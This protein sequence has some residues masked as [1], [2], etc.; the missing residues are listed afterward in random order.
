MRL[1]WRKGAG[2]GEA[3]LAIEDAR[4]TWL[5]QIGTLVLLGLMWA[6]F[7]HLAVF[8]R[9]RSLEGVD[10]RSSN[11]ALAAQQYAERL[12]GIADA[13]TQLVAAEYVSG[14]RGRTLGQVLK[15]RDENNDALQEVFM[16]DP[17]GR[18]LLSSR[19]TSALVQPLALPREAPADRV[20]VLPPLGPESP[21]NALHLVPMVR[22]IMVDGVLRGWAG[23][24]IGSRRFADPLGATQLEFDTL[25][26]VYRQ[27]GVLLASWGNGSA[28]MRLQL[29]ASRLAGP[30]ADGGADDEAVLDA[31]PRVVSVRPLARHAVSVAVGI[32][33]PDAL[34]DA[35]QRRRFYL[36]VCTAVTGL[37]A[38]L[39]LVVA[40]ATRRR[41]HMAQGLAAARERLAAL[42][43]RL[44][45][46]VVR[47]TAQLEQA[48][49][50]LE[51]F[52][53]SVAHD[54]RAPLAS[55]EG[56]S[57]ALEP[58]V[59]AGGNPKLLHYVQRIRASAHHMGEIT[60]ALLALARLGR[61][62]IDRRPVDLARKARDCVQML[63]EREPQREVRVGIMPALPASGDP[64]L[65]RQVMENLVGNAWKFLRDTPDAEI[66]V[67][68]QTDAQGQTVYFVRDN[69][70]GFDMEYAHALF[71]PFQRLH[72][73]EFAGSGIG[74]ATV[75]RIVAL[76]GGRIWAEAK[77]GRGATFFFTLG[78]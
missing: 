3:G 42:N 2:D 67:G 20:T 21:P 26:A 78:S 51:S 69:G 52:S 22:P 55:I 8:D 73:P 47:R 43:E 46:E 10:S 39:S 48:N 44:E 31:V 49:R 60:D 61:K 75:E 65:L 6:A 28:R 70:P 62:T 35:D 41:V 25:L 12:L 37:V 24:L 74:L 38:G 9:Q 5:Q 36:L 33:R 34:R 59:A 15:D 71:K 57:A 4:G 14:A 17:R 1:R 19:T 66:E 40:R 58:S 72:G 27:D 76:H 45:H 32:S 16:L 63:R 77:P 23:V 56:F 18:V 11:L 54:L 53:Y 13:V 50:D 64:A 68:Q 7:V 30:G 29:D